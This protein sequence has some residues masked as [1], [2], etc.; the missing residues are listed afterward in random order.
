MKYMLANVQKRQEGLDAAEAM[1]RKYAG[2]GNYLTNI[3]QKHEREKGF[4][5]AINKSG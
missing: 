1:I 4:S 5:R 3:L 2:K